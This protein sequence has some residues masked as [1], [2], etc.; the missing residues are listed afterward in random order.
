MFMDELLDVLP[1][2]QNCP[3]VHGKQAVARPELN[4]PWSHNTGSA[5]EVGQ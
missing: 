3:A 4:V 2:T 1:S 5:D